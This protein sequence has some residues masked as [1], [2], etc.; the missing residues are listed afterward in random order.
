M[1]YP[2]LIEA[3]ISD[4]FRAC[5][6]QNRTIDTELFYTSRWGEETCLRIILTPKLN[7]QG[8]VEGCLALMEDVMPRKKAEKELK[9]ARDELELRVE[10][11]TNKLLKANKK[12][13]AGNC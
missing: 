9:T 2:P 10:E 1:T 7:E 8:Y 3:G 5:I 12:A 4:L 11:R 6:R 13:G